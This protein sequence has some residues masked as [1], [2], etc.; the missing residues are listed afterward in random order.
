MVGFVRLL[1][2]KSVDIGLVPVDLVDAKLE[3]NEASIYRS[4]KD[5]IIRTLNNLKR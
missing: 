1:G 2:T 3:D 5:N 4:M